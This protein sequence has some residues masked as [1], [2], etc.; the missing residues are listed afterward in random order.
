M[1]TALIIDDEAPSRE[2][3]KTLLAAAADIEVLGECA[4][5]IEGL[6]A[7]RRLRPDVVFLDIQMPRVSGLE[8]VGMI[9]ASALPQIV[10]VTAYDEHALQAF[11]EHAADY[12]L[13]PIDPQRLARTL[14]WLRSGVRR[15]GTAFPGSA[16]KLRQV[17]CFGRNRIFLLPLDEVEFVHTDIAGVQVV[18]KERQGTTELS[19]KILQERSS[20]IRCHRQFLVNLDQIAEIELLDNGAA[21]IVTRSGRR[22]P[23]S[24][25]HL[26]E[27]K[28]RLLIP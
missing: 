5:A 27:M 28:D 24:R 4:N 25:R 14:D 11:E 10:F 22:V 1:L 23:V 17:P 19:L 12:L 3:L 18:G 8:M 7:I 26:R 6:S 20:L 2:E 13:K 9:D 15:S 21:E 16:E